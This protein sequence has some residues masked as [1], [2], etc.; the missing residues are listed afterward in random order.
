[1]TVAVGERFKVKASFKN[2]LDIPLQNCEFSFE[3]AGNLKP[4]TISTE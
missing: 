3:A 2:P 1:M 4:V